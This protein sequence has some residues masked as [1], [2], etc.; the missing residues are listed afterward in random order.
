MRKLERLRRRKEEFFFFLILMAVVDRCG[1][2]FESMPRKKKKKK[3]HTSLKTEL[4][5]KQNI[6]LPTE[7]VS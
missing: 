1:Q 6:F 3:R 5:T 4:P 7:E 2:R